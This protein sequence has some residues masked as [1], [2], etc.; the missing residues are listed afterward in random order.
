MNSSVCA[1]WLVAAACQRWNNNSTLSSIRQSDFTVIVDC[2]HQQFDLAILQVIRPHSKRHV[3][4]FNR[5]CRTPGYDQQSCRQTYTQNTLYGYF[6]DLNKYDK[7]LSVTPTK[8]H[9]VEKKLAA[10]D[11]IWIQ[12][13]PKTEATVFENDTFK[14]ICLFGRLQCSIVLNTYVESVNSV[15]INLP[16]VPKTS[17]FLFF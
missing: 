7:Q 17:T 14:T 15:Q 4:L 3:D 6:F 11:V 10:T 2:S 9:I 5:F 12:G 1:A 13:G 16:C 8:T